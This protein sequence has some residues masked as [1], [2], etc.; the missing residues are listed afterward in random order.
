MS[1]K[2]LLTVILT[3]RGREAFT[4]RWV[5]YHAKIGL[6]WKVIV[7]DG[8]PSD[9]TESLFKSSGL[10]AEYLRYKDT[11]TA[12]Y[13]RKFADLIERARTPY[14][15]F[16]DN[17]DFI[18]PYGVTRAL[19]FL[20]KHP[21][22]VSGGGAVLGLGIGDRSL[23]TGPSP[24]WGTWY[25]LRILFT[26]T[27]REET[28]AA[29]RS[30]RTITN[31]NSIWFGVHRR[32]ALFAAA[33]PTVDPGIKDIQVH[34]LLVTAMMAAQG[35]QRTDP[36]YVSYAR[37]LNSS[38]NRH[39]YNDGVFNRLLGTDLAKDCKTLAEVVSKAAAATDGTSRQVICDRLQAALVEYY[40]RD[41]KPVAARARSRAF[42]GRYLHTA[43]AKLP[44]VHPTMQRL[45]H[46]RVK[47]Q[48]IAA[49]ADRDARASLDRSMQQITT[50][51]G[52]R[53]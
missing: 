21:D 12:S 1:D 19:E 27:M 50:V 43:R 46:A 15:M 2:S 20:Q 23:N 32:D 7:G 53:D 41:A 37:Q 44:C 31:Y 14:V 39:L 47:R 34:E 18:V 51:V 22:Y 24:A 36:S 49:G 42:I 4:P 35:K 13:F 38:Q 40:S 5:E 28:L 45:E 29:E 10:D 8:D 17:D 16:T 3:L 30:V 9:A 48:I 33:Q 26:P 25:G 11:D 52:S 6:P